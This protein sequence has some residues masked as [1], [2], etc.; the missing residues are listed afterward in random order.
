MQNHNLVT[1]L[2][3]LIG[4]QTALTNKLQ[5]TRDPDLA[6]AISTEISEILHRII[7]TQNL[8]FQSDSAQLK[9]SVTAVKSADGALS[10]AI[11]NFTKAADLI[12]AVSTYLGYVDK[13]ID[14]AKTVGM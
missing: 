9:D 1:L 3:S 4:Q 2:N 12:N 11:N 14:L 6:N 10:A 8:L 5:I 7:L 13:A